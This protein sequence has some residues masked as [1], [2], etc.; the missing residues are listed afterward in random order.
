MGCIRWMDGKVEDQTDALCIL[1]PSAEMYM[2]ALQTEV[3]DSN[4]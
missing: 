4:A 1:Y 3:Y 2:G